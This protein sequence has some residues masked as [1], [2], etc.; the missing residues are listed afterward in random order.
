MPHIKIEDKVVYVPDTMMGEEFRNLPVV[1]EKV[2]PQ[3]DVF[4]TRGGTDSS[5]VE[6]GQRY[7]IRD[8]NEVEVWPAS[9]SGQW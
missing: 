8:G 4:L 1:R 9:R 5:K 3:D 6:A 2:R 7:D